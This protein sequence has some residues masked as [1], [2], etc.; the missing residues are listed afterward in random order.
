MRLSENQKESKNQQKTMLVLDKK[1]SKTIEEAEKLNNW[2][3]WAGYER[4]AGV[5]EET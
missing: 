5:N 3:Y 2:K 1:I 4:K